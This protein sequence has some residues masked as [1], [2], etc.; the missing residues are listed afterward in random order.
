MRRRR[1]G[2]R[3]L[4]TVPQVSRVLARR[5]A[6]P[7]WGTGNSGSLG[8]SEASAGRHLAD[9]FGG[10]RNS[11]RGFVDGGFRVDVGFSSRG[12]GPTRGHSDIS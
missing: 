6:G 12:G 5:K 1:A 2:H 10:R 9:L 7:A 11:S 4:Q 3:W 8:Q